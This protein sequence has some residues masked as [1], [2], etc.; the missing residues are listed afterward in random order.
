RLL[1][2]HSIPRADGAGV[3]LHQPGRLRGGAMRAVRRRAR[4]QAVVELA[5]GS[6]ILITLFIIAGYLTE[7][8]F[9]GLKMHEAAA[10]AAY[11]AMHGRSQETRTGSVSQL[12]RV[13]SGSAASPGGRATDRY[14]DFNGVNTGGPSTIA[15]TMTHAAAMSVQCERAPQLDDVRGSTPYVAM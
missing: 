13:T 6:L 14:R 1:R 15:Q 8:Q 2:A 12:S 7:V 9:L 5:L 3:P 11:D 10:Y 4:G